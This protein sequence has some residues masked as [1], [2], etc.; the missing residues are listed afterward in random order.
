MV[1]KDRPLPSVPKLAD[2]PVEQVLDH[3]KAPEQWTRL[4]AKRTLAERDRKTVAPAIAK[5]VKQLDAKDAD[6]QRHLLEALWACQAIDHVNTDLLARALRSDDGHVRAAATRVL[7]DWNDRVPDAVRWL[8]IQ[9]ADANPRVRLQAVQALA[10]VPSAE[11]VQVGMRALDHPLD[12]FLEFALTKL[13]ILHKPRWQPEFQA[14]RLTFEGDA[15]RMA[16]ALKAIRGDAVPT[17]VG[18][19]VKDKVPPENLAEVLQLIASLGNP[20]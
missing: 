13:A 5:W 18:L 14:G 20:G 17:L 16:F 1:R 12:P 15:R 8:S 11:A 6:L 9:V 10:R 19:V 2:A 4:Y 3:L 7:G